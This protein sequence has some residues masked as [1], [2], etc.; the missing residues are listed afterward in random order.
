MK[1]LSNLRFGRGV[2]QLV[3][4]A[5]VAATCAIAACGGG[6]VGGGNLDDGQDSGTDFQLDGMNGDGPSIGDVP[7]SSDTRLD[8]DSA[9]ADSV[10]DAT[11]IPPNLYMLFDH[12]GSMNDDVTGGTKWTLAVK[13]IDALVEGSPD[14][15]NFGLKFFPPLGAP[16]KTCDPSFFST[17]DVPVAP[18]STSRAEIE[19]ALAKASPGGETPMAIAV[20]TAIT[21]M[22]TAKLSDGTR[23]VILI[24]DGDPNGCGSLTDVINDA[25]VGPTD[26][27]PVDVYVIGAP[28]GT[29]QNLSQIAA[30]GNGKRTPTCVAD[31]T[32]PTKSCD[33]EISSTDFETEL[34]AALKDI[35]GKALTCT[36]DVPTGGEAGTVDPSKVN[37]DVTDSSGDTITLDR[38]PTHTDGWDYTDGGATITVY[39]PECDKIKTD[40]TEKVQ[41]I[42]GCKTKGPS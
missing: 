38:D 6:V 33:Y 27:P 41:I 24:T 18:L 4:I 40:G 12:S 11:R 29:V 30:A 39:G 36:F 21:Y 15:M 13:A 1:H 25:T 14:D 7:S 5:S 22:N 10:V 26:T 35:E 9:C 23:I 19:A 28:G 3:G 42:L 34:L 31:T 37:V 8:P 16:S 20:Q 2:A 32:D 17:P